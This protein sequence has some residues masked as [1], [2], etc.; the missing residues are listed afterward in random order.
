MASKKSGI[1]NIKEKSIII[2]PI[3]SRGG[4]DGIHLALI[5]LV[6]ILVLLVVSISYTKEIIIRNES[7]AN[8]TYGAA[9][10]TCMIPKS[11]AAG[12]SSAFSRII[13]SYANSNSSL[14]L[15]PYLA[16]TSTASEQY[17]PYS[18]AWLSRISGYNPATNQSF[19][20]AAMINDTNNS[21]FIPF[22][23]VTKPTNLT[24]N[25]V[26][27]T[28]VV[29]L[30]GKYACTI[31]KP[32]QV[33]WFID[34]YSPGAISSLSNAI[35]IEKRFNSSV[36]LTLKMLYTQASVK[37]AN[38]YGL[39]EAQALSG[40]LF[41]AS[42][43]PNFSRFSEDLNSLYTGSYVSSQTLGIISNQTGLNY[44]AMSSCL[45]SYPQVF[46]RQN[47]LS[48]YYNITTSPIVVTNCD[49]MSLPQTA[50]EAVCYSNSSLC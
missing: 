47:L 42:L 1:G 37:V 4:L 6:I 3:G 43:Q 35:A 34:P 39:A 49:Y 16:N 40:Y 25:S 28:G 22:V 24:K 8:C 15:I 14:S 30:A 9:N 38:A 5:V 50:E 20:F 7:A 32:T 44:T 48:N 12:I 33:L 17:L 10:G 31:Q 18:K 23:E 11:T 26:V 45:N 27:S 13:A 2:K 46:E 29:K 21:K 41:C 19:Y 36:N